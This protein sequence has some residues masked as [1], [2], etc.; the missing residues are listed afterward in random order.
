MAGYIGNKTVLDDNVVKTSVEAATD[1]NT[2]TD[3]DHSKLNA[4]EASATADQ[5]AAEILTAI[6]TVDGTGTGLDADL[7]DGQEGSYYTGYADTA[8]A[9]LVDSSPAALNTL[10]EL[11]AAIGDDANFST[12]VTNSIATK[13]PLAGG[14]FTGDVTFT[15]ASYNAVWDKSDNALK[16]ADN[17]KLKFGADPNLEIYHNGGS[18][19]IDDIGSGSLALRTNGF[20]INMMSTSSEM[21]GVFTPNGSVDLYYDNVK[22]FE[23]TSTGIDVTGNITV[24][25]TVDGRDIA[26][27]IP[28]SL[29]SAGQVLTVNSGGSAAE[30]AAGGDVVNDTSPQ[31]GGDLQTN[32]HDVVMGNNDLI[33]LGTFSGQPAAAFIFSNGNTLSLNS[34]GATR[35]TGSN[36]TFAKAGGGEEYAN[37]VADGATSLYHN[38]IKKFETTSTGID[39][40]GAITVNGSALTSGITSLA[41]DTSPQL[42]GNLET[43]GNHII[44][45]GSDVIKLGNS[46]G[47]RAEISHTGTA[48]GAFVLNN[49]AGDFAMRCVDGNSTTR[50]AY[51]GFTNTFEDFMIATPND[52]VQLN[53]NNSEKLKT[54]NTGIDVTGAI[55]VNGSALTGAD[56]YAANE[57]SP[58]G[59]PSATGTNAIA[60]GDS[61][62]ASGNDSIAIGETTVASGHQGISLGYNA[63]SGYR[64]I[65]GPDSN[66][67]GGNAVAF[68]IAFNG[69]NYG[70]AGDFSLA[71]GYQTNV[72]GDWAIG[73][74][75]N[76]Y[77]TGDR[78]VAIG[79]YNQATG[80]NATAVGYGSMAGGAQ[81]YA[82]G[83]QTTGVRSVT[84]GRSALA[85]AD[86]AI[87]LGSYS[88]A[89]AVRAVAIGYHS[90]ANQK[91]K[92]AYSTSSFSAQGDSQ[93]G[94]FILRSDTTDATP[95]AMT[96]N[97][98]TADATNQIVAASDTCIT[99]HGTITAMQNGAQ[100][101][102]GWEIKGMLVNDGGTTTLALGNVSDM[103]ATNASSWAVA[104]SADNTNNALKIQVTGEASHNIR[105]V[106]NIHTAEVTYA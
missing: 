55:T 14:T 86:E 19:Y 25:G 87:S 79:A 34:W 93:G 47:N 90:L 20:G 61:A 9:N 101:H 12:T 105:W 26:T 30:W 10:N 96:T 77:V 76:T 31:L 24:S 97:N 68:G 92:I 33:K 6:K 104:L 21:M 58:A 7:L 28:S 70:A 23:T 22:K 17:T 69:S 27:N 66:A 63:K 59:Q 16:F 72:V 18:S 75:P 43:N 73:L 62:A 53:F 106:A 95:E 94:T 84:L 45:G 3:A 50:K 89:N 35:I 56:L 1:S 81:S 99:F 82:F 37:F 91:G 51:F 88:K 65:A 83:G 8:V 44:T 29:G 42:G 52:K 48:T 71:I 13:M 100:A 5:T 39:I 98:A 46:S 49:Y 32:G 2:F 85:Y 60:I 4:I 74:G 64:S 11:A 40:T 80:A 102:A 38:N 57:S 41:A 67:S 78:A 54:T 103:A 15:G 36:M